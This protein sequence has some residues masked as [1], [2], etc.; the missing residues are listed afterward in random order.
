MRGLGEI[1]VMMMNASMIEKILGNTIDDVAA[2]TQKF[3]VE[4]RSDTGS[5]EVEVCS[6]D[7]IV[8]RLSP[9]SRIVGYRSLMLR[10]QYPLHFASTTKSALRFRMGATTF[11]VGASRCF[12]NLRPLISGHAILHE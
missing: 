4:L 8:V 10:R 9:S 6:G 2:A 7:S 12:L 5:V 3:H 1:F 11:N